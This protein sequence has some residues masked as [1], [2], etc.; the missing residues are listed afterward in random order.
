M[1]NIHRSLPS[2]IAPGYVV[3]KAGKIERANGR[4]GDAV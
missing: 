3:L 4:Q 1:P 2:S